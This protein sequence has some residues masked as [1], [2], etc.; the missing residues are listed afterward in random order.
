MQMS[1]GVAQFGDQADIA[2]DE[3]GFSLGRH[4]AQAELEGG[5]PGVHAGALRQARVFGVLDDAQAHT[6]RGGQGLAHHA[7][8]QNGA[9]VVGHGDGASGFERGKV[10]ERLAL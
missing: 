9:A 8:F 4:A 3:A 2:L 7:V 1:A 5:R 6:R 10:V